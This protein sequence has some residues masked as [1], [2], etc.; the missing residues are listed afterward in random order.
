[1]IGEQRL[2]KFFCCVVVAGIATVLI[3]VTSQSVSTDKIIQAQKI[4]NTLNLTELSGL[5]SLNYKKNTQKFRFKIDSSL[6]NRTPE[7]NLFTIE[8]KRSKIYTFRLCQRYFEEIE[9]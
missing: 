9:L 6:E 2:K 8:R 5:K 3:Q 1:M 4:V 7:K